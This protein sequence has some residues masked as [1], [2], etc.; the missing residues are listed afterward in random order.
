MSSFGDREP[1][2]LVLLFALAVQ[3]LFLLPTAVESM[4]LGP[5]FP[6]SRSRV[7]GTSRIR[8][9]FLTPQH[10]SNAVKQAAA[11]AAAALASGDYKR[12]DQ[13]EM[14]ATTKAPQRAPPKHHV[15]NSP[16]FYIRL[17]PSPYVYVPSLG[18]ISPPAT[19]FNFL[20]P[21][22]NFLTNG[23]PVGIYQLK[24]QLGTSQLSSSSSSNAI[25]S[26]VVK[27]SEAVTVSKKPKPSETVTLRPGP[28]HAETQPPVD[29]E[30]STLLSESISDSIEEPIDESISTESPISGEDD[31]SWGSVQEPDN[32]AEGFSTSARPPS[33]NKP[34][35]SPITWL[36]GPYYFNGLPT[37]LFLLNSLE[38]ISQ[39]L[40]RPRIPPRLG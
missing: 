39:A 26:S 11:A 35:D 22:V 15:T 33:E 40:G 13:Q 21:N 18:Y 9:P 8:G 1:A 34:T 19:N 10:T 7:R 31:F 2:H 12:K 17:P 25:S 14:T 24:D 37:H 5:L 29:M 23:K 20:R 36:K 28:T 6:P 27:P 3:V 30:V 32:S 16:I 4:N 38:K